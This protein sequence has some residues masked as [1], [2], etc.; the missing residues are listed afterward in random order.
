[1][2]DWHPTKAGKQICPQCSHQRKHKKDPCLSV[3]AV[4]G[5]LVWNCHNCGFKGGTNAPRTASEM[6]GR[7]RHP[8]RYGGENGG[9]HSQRQS[10]KLAH[11][12]VSPRRRSG[13]PQVPAYGDRKSVGWGKSVFGSV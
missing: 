2:T 6:A 10:G 9:Q 12:P 11:I 1:M 5:G 13:E 3:S 7:S 8:I 4:D